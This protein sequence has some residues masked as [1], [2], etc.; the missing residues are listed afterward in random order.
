MGNLLNA[1]GRICIGIERYKCL[2]DRTKRLDPALYHE[3]RFFAFDPSDTNILPDIEPYRSTYDA[4]RPKWSQ[5]LVVGDKLGARALPA[6]VRDIPGA[7]VVYL[8]RQV[9]RVASSWN[10]RALRPNDRWPRENDFTAAVPRWNEVNALALQAVDAL[11]P[12]MLVIEYER[13]FAGDEGHPRMLERLLEVPHD[14]TM[15][16][17]YRRAAEF[18]VGKVATK[19][20]T[21]LDGQEQLIAA[22][23]DM[24]TYEALVG[25]ARRRYEGAVQ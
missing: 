4:M 24:D 21:V 12:R 25:H 18:Y 3:E 6:V 19:P 16:A 15:L 8:L 20:P 17:A 14:E 13:F 2:F 7:R 1:H 10:V 22:E 5:A 11:G 23:A 9:A